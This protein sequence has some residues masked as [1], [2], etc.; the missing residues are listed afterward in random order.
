MNQ[1]TIR[2]IP[3]GG[4]VKLKGTE[5]APVWVRGEYCKQEKKFEL[6][7]FDDVSHVIMKKP[8]ALAFIGFTF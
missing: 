8:E 3:R 2:S 1:A 6:Y 5:S 4:Y 7:K